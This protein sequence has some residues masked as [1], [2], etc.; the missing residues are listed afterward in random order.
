MKTAN[1]TPNPDSPDVADLLAERYGV[2]KLAAEGYA[3]SISKNPLEGVPGYLV[4][5]LLEPDRFPVEGSLAE[6]WYVTEAPQQDDSKGNSQADEDRLAW[7]A[8][9]DAMADLRGPLS[10]L[11]LCRAVGL[12]RPT[13]VALDSN[14]L[15][16]LADLARFTRGCLDNEWGLGDDEAITEAESFIE[17]VAT[18]ASWAANHHS[19]LLSMAPEACMRWIQKEY[20]RTGGGKAAASVVGAIALRPDGRDFAVGM[21]PL[22]EWGLDIDSLDVGGIRFPSAS[23]LSVCALR[24]DLDMLFAAREASGLGWNERLI[25]SLADGPRDSTLFETTIWFSEA[26]LGIAKGDAR[27]VGEKLARS[28]FQEAIAEGADPRPVALKNPLFPSNG[29][30]LAAAELSGHP[31]AQVEILAA[32]TRIEGTSIKEGVDGTL[33]GRELPSRERDKM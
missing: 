21:A 10:A 4:L 30:P 26:F 29:D 16:K 22:A 14:V 6:Q 17:W 32:L 7:G 2:W 24:L 8:K 11:L 33:G 9:I 20:V 3:L 15:G 13:P 5:L 1:P 18:T 25:W 23:L 27:E 28:L 31:V 19:T 12:L